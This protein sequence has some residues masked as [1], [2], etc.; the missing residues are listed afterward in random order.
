[1]TSALP[2]AAANEIAVSPLTFSLAFTSAPCAISDLTAAALPACDANIS[3]VVPLVVAALASAP[4]AASVSTIAA[5][6]LRL[7]ISSGV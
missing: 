2:K 5:S 7:A 3:A 6:P 1:M 4:A